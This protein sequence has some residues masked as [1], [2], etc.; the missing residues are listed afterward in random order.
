MGLVTWV[1][2]VRRGLAASGLELG[3]VWTAQNAERYG[4]RS[5]DPILAFSMLFSSKP[6]VL[7]LFSP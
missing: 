7:S 1:V 2:V 4:V 5:T 3:R 6:P